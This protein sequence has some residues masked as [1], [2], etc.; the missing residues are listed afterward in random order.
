MADG[1]PAI[2][3]GVPPRLPSSWPC[4]RISSESSVQSAVSALKRAP[5]LPQSPFRLRKI[6]LP[7]TTITTT[8]SMP[9]GLIMRRCTTSSASSLHSITE[10]LPILLV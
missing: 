10:L 8:T 5:I 3:P 6:I 4:Q 2:R 1:S 7:A 9:P